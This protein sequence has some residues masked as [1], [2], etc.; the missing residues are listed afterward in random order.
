MTRQDIQNQIAKTINRETGAVV[1]VTLVSN[2]RL[3]VFAE[4]QADINA[5]MNIMQQVPSVTLE[6]TESYADDGMY[7]AFYS[8]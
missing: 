3:S 6:S 5:A 2:T 1:E 8:F 7:V 4:N